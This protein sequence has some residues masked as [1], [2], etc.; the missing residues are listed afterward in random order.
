MLARAGAVAAVLAELRLGGRV[1]LNKHTGAVKVIGW[2]PTGD[3]IVDSILQNV[4]DARPA[5]PFTWMRSFGYQ[6]FNELSA[7]LGL[8]VGATHHRERADRLVEL[9]S[10]ADLAESLRTA[11]K[12]SL[13][14]GGAIDNPAMTLGV[15]LWGSELLDVVLGLHAP[16]DHVRFG[17]RAA[18]DWLGTSVRNVAGAITYL[19]PVTWDRAHRE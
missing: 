8:A 10:A 5:L 18:D 15:V 2:Q 3:P 17:H 1:T 14:A 9:P 16:A 11:L 19:G 6:V 13:D 7:S 4:I 12:E